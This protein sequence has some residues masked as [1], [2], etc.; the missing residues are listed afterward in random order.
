MK[1]PG[2][3]SN[4]QS[5]RKAPAA[6]RRGTPGPSGG[7]SNLRPTSGSGPAPSR[8]PIIFVVDD[9]P[10]LLILIE[11][12]LS[13]ENWKVAYVSSGAEALAWLQTNS[14]DLLLLDLKLSDIEGREFV[15]ALADGGRSVPFIVITGQGD[16]RVA[17][18]MMQRGALDYL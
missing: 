7:E 14:A 8:V 4:R 10:G 1:T 9:D 17:V 6:R 2:P 15:R 11:S 18:E 12:V 3:K 13:A 5:S 16:E